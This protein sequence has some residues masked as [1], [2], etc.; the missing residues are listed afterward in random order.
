MNFDRYTKE[1]LEY[2]VSWTLDT[3]T[4]SV[5]EASE[6]YA[7]M[8]EGGEFVLV[9]MGMRNERIRYGS[10]AEALHAAG[11]D[12]ML[13]EARATSCSVDAF[14][15]HGKR[16]PKHFIDGVELLEYPWEK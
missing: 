6:C 11:M 13:T 16:V 10:F 7:I 2:E 9:V 3:D 5:V 12:M 8:L 4:K 15:R 14:V 1:D